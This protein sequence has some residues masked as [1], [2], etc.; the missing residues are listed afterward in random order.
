MELDGLM[1]R[2]LGSDRV[3][4]TGGG[5]FLGSF[6]RERLEGNVVA[7]C[8]PR[9]RDY[10]LRDESVVHRLFEEFRPT[11]VVHAAVHLRGIGYMAQHPAEIFDDNVRMNFLIQEASR[12]Y[13]V[14]KFV[15]IGTICSYPKFAEVPFREEQLWDGLPEEVLGPY[16][17]AKKFMLVQTQTY[18]KQY[19]FNGIHLLLVNTYGPRD[20]FSDEGGHVIPA[21]IMRFWNAARLGQPEVVCWGD[22]SPTRDFLY[23]E[24]AAE[25]VLRATALYDSPEPVNLGAG[26]EIS[27]KE[28]SELIAE[29]TGFKG[30][31]VWDT[32]RPNGQPRRMLDTSKA[33][34][35]FG[36]R[37]STPFREGLRRTIAWYQDEYLPNQA[38]C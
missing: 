10:D 36:F 31:I 11:L 21:L 32:T 8:T 26:V 37:A 34:E 5:G 1:R 9:S 6:L 35:R 14:R 15:G 24:D 3:L 23:V 18:A 30:R 13:G 16:G 12:R 28:L 38:T 33:A 17:L 25:G 4:L 2:H 19:G 22:G 7:L 20:H 27:M 29:L